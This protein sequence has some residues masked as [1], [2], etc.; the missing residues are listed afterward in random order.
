MWFNYFLGLSFGQKF[1]FVLQADIDCFTIRAKS[2]GGIVKNQQGKQGAKRLLLIQLGV[3]IIIALAALGVVDL[4]AATSAI[5]G[6]IVC[7]LPNAYFAS[8]LFKHNGA[9]AARQIVNGFYKGEALKLMLSV[10]LFA[11]VFKYLKINPLVFF[12]A[13][14]AAQMVFWFAPLI[15]VNKNRPRT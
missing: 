8:K 12:V 3:T 6:G 10:A 11:L 13:Y 1:N 4:V 9:H 15:V 2:K 14:I 5:A 7:V